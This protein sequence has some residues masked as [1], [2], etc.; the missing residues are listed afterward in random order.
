V[1]VHPSLLFLCAALVCASFAVTGHSICKVYEEESKKQ[2]RSKTPTTTKEKKQASPNKGPAASVLSSASLFFFFL[3]PSS[4]V[5]SRLP[6]S[7]CGAPAAE[8]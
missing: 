1:P 2:K 5:F 3:P 7:T 6:L 4:S 8:E